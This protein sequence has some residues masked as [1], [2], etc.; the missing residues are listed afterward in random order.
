MVNNLL[1]QFDFSVKFIQAPD[2][3]VKAINSGL[4][5]LDLV[6]Q[7]PSCLSNLHIGILCRFG[8]GLHLLHASSEFLPEFF[9]GMLAGLVAENAVEA[10][11]DLN[12]LAN[13]LQGGIGFSFCLDQGFTEL[14][15][16]PVDIFCEVLHFGQ[17]W[18]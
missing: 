15:N 14:I 7:K 17:G 2:F 16:S 13:F 3:L 10:I 1:D 6:P 4:N 18:K 11:D 12:L 8:E 9:E 5:F